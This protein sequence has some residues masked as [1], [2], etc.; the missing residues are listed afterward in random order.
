MKAVVQASPAGPALAARSRRE[1]GYFGCDLWE[2]AAD[3]PRLVE[4]R[5]SP[6]VRDPYRFFAA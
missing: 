6:Y 3:N 1:R 5:T 4:D 2:A